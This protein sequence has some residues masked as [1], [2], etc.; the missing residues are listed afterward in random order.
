MKLAQS[1]LKRK[2]A[3]REMRS[4]AQRLKYINDIQKNKNVVR[5]IE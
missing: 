2:I 3:V 4:K 5:T 1:R